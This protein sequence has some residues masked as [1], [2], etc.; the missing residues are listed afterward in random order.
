MEILPQI[1]VT[2]SMIDIGFEILL[3]YH[4]INVVYSLREV[5]LVPI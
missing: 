4:L 3:R 1:L 2:Y 5:G